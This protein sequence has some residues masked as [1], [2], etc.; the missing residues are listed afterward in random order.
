ML[1]YDDLK[2]MSAPL[3][4]T[5][6][7]CSYDEACGKK[8]NHSYRKIV[9]QN[10]KPAIAARMTSKPVKFNKCIVLNNGGIVQGEPIKY[11]GMDIANIIIDSARKSNEPICYPLTGGN[12][13]KIDNIRLLY[14]FVSGKAVARFE[15]EKIDNRTQLTVEELQAYVDPT[16]I[17][18]T[19]FKS[20]AV[21]H[22]V[23]TDNL[24]QD[25]LGNYSGLPIKESALK[26]SSPLIYIL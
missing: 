22:S 19:T 4:E 1:N 25:F 20:V 12:W 14:L 21:I 24:P 2:S 6:N 13:S 5:I 8:V 17:L 15:V 9:E 3:R 23:T 10:R 26:G 7:R 16:P 11:C 18:H